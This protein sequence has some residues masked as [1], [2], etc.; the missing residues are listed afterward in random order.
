MDWPFFLSTLFRRLESAC[1]LFCD[2]P[3]LG[4]E[5]WLQLQQV[6]DSHGVSGCRL[7]WSDL[8]RYS[9][10]QERRVPMGG[11]VGTCEV[12]DPDGSR[13]PWWLAASLVH[14]G[15]GASMGLGRVVL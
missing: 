5:L 14:V 9:N 3:P 15:K 4:R 1:R 8:A 12:D 7:T 10:R 11:L 2:A 6:A 13:Y